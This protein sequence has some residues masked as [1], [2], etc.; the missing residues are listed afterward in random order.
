MMSSPIKKNNIVHRSKCTIKIVKGNIFTSKVQTLVNTVNTVG[1]MGAGIALEF[2]L[3]YPDMYLQYLKLCK[4]RK[5]VIGKLWIYKAGNRW[6]LNFPTK[7]HWKDDSKIEYLEAGLI[8]FVETFKS[9][10]ITSIAFPILGSS[11]G[12]IPEEESLIIMKKHLCKCDIPIEIYKYN[13]KSKDD[14]YILLSDELM[15]MSIED[16]TNKTGIQKGYARKIKAV[17]SDKKIRSISKISKVDG[18]GIKT[19]EKL[20]LYILYNRENPEDT[21]KKEMQLS[22][23]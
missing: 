18:L 20:F 11:N 5:L 2:R 12:K 10:G 17:L 4:S 3:R 23:F 9:K 21:T 16:I 19:L 14:L 7:I 15:Q 6:I 22:L 1:I 13:E 8:K